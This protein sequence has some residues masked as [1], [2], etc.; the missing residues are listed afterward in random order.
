MT[1]VGRCRPLGIVVAVAAVVA[2]QGSGAVGIVREMAPCRQKCL[3][4]KGWHSSG[5]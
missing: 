3:V 4:L 1:K 5:R 2:L